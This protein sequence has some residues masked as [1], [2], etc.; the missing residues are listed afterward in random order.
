ME[1]GPA[2]AA[3]K[4]QI[5]DTRV[6]RAPIGKKGGLMNPVVW[7]PSGAEP[8]VRTVVEGVTNDFHDVWRYRG[9]LPGLFFP[10]VRVGRYQLSTTARCQRKVAKRVEV[11]R[12][13]EKT[14]RTTMSR[15][16]FRRIKRGM[17]RAQVRRIVGYDGHG[18][19]YGAWM[20]RTYD[21]MPFWRYSNV[22]FRHG[23]VVRKSWNVDHD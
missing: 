4:P 11:V 17:T 14:A 16:E 21:M 12:V 8:R 5:D 18:S 22:E 20:Y 3:A 2:L 7:C 10:R 23:R 9:T 15:A 13:K 6:E 1:S 19:R